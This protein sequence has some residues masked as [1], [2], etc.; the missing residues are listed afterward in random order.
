MS[1]TI[2]TG[3][4]QPVGNRPVLALSYSN[5]Q[6]LVIRANSHSVYASYSEQGL[7]HENTRFTIRFESTDGMKIPFVKPSSGTIFFA[8]TH[9]SQDATLSMWSF[10]CNHGDY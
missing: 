5:S 6:C 1:G 10:D 4:A 2:Q 9:N 8:S 7:E 3:T